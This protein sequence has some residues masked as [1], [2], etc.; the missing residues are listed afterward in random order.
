MHTENTGNKTTP[1]IYKT[2]VLQAFF[3]RKYGP[4]SGQEVSASF[5]KVGKNVGQLEGYGMLH[6][7]D[8]C[9]RSFYLHQSSPKHV[10]ATELIDRSHC[11]ERFGRST[12]E[13]ARKD[14]VA[15]PVGC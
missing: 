1:K 2:A 6:T 11:R 9:A 7:L 14:Q 3:S 4:F 15:W 5:G 8:V 12:K 13:Y 10:G